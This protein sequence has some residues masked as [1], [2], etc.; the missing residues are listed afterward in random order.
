M[1]SVYAMSA[2]EAAAEAA[3]LQSCH[4]K[5]LAGAR[6]PESY[7][8]QDEAIDAGATLQSTADQ[9]IVMVSD[10]YGINELEAAG[11]LVGL[12]ADFVKARERLAA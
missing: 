4:D 2:D 3:R 12:A 8:A 6:R 10:A 11:L 9:V 1:N 5:C 7:S